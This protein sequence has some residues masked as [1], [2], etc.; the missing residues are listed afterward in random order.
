VCDGFG[1]PALAPSPN[2]QL[3]E[4]MVPSASLL[5]L[6][7]PHVRFEQLKKKDAVGD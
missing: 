5:V 6:L 4:T 1:P 2:V 7:N 3:Y